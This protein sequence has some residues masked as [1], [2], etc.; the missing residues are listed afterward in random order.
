MG[1]MS[2]HLVLL[3]E[4]Y[5]TLRYSRLASRAVLGG[6]GGLGSR[7]LPGE[8]GGKVAMVVLC[9]STWCVCVCVCVCGEWVGAGRLVACVG[10]YIEYVDMGICRMCVRMEV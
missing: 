6:S 1:E 2:L 8:K 4:M 3:Q 5:V 7:E 10:G 9:V